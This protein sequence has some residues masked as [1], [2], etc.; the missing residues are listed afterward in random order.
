MYR[1]HL[2][3][4]EREQLQHRTRQHHLAPQTRDRLEMVRLSHAGWSIPK[5]AAHLRAH[6][7]TVRR[8]IKTFLQAVFDA[9]SDNPCPGKK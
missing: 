8:W 3:E 4:A 6:E 2:N 9:L 5:I 7:Q 1:V